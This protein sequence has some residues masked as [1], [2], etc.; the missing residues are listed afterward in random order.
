MNGPRLRR[1]PGFLRHVLLLMMATIV[2]MPLVWMLSTSFKPLSEIMSADLHLIPRHWAAF[3]NYAN[4][5]GSV[6]LLR[7]M[8]NGV[9]VSGG[10]L[11]LQ[12]LVAIPC[13]YALAKLRWPGKSRFLA[14]VLLCLMV[15]HQAP[16]IP[17]Y[18][19][20]YGLG[21]LDTYTALIAPFIFSAFGV[22]LLRQYFMTIPDDLIHAARLDGMSEIAIMWRIVVPAAAP[23]I[24]AFSVFSVIVHWNDLFWPLIVVTTPEL[25]TP[26]RGVVFFK[27][28]EFGNDYGAMM[29]MAVIITLPLVILFLFLQR[30]FIDGITMTGF[31]G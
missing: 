9:L 1:F 31:K 12:L 30:R 2:L 7:F 23:A 17:I 19:G 4:A 27:N 16:A 3:E 14:I 26:P 8:L 10:I 15:P 20:L 13:A 24:V 25:A 21:L 29:A 6:P 11:V 22:F 28:D 18:I 5:L